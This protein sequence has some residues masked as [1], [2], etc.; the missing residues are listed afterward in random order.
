MSAN[1]DHNLGSILEPIISV[2][3]W[4]TSC[5]AVEMGSVHVDVTF[6]EA[7]LGDEP[8]SKVRFQ[9]ALKRAVIKVYVSKRDPIKVVRETVDRGPIDESMYE[10]SEKGKT[11]YSVSGNAAAST[12]LTPFK[13]AAEVKGSVGR[14]FDESTKTKRTVRNH[15]VQQ[16]AQGDYYCWE[17]SPRTN[18]VL[19]GKIWDPVKEPRL[20]TLLTSASAKSGDCEVRIV[21]ECRRQDLSIRN[22]QL[23]DT[24]LSLPAFRGTKNNMAAAEAVIKNMIFERG[25]TVDN[26]EEPFQTLTITSIIVPEG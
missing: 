23:K 14:E 20:K 11:A 5:D 25:F 4:R 19:T 21:I 6:L 12:G 7:F 3:A 26:F 10:K 13:A 9:A 22:V 1:Y 24:K 15:N 8:E 16:Y 17:I 18:S 2:E